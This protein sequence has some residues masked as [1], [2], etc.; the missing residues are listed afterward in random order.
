MLL[1]VQIAEVNNP[2]FFF[3]QRMEILQLP[4]GLG[5]FIHPFTEEI[6]H[7]LETCDG[8]TGFMHEG[9]HVDDP[10]RFTRPWFTWPDALF[11]KFVDKC[12]A[13]GVI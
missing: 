10:T 6:L 3:N 11:C 12:I 8:D 9:F 4:E 2:L 13:E 7:M 5:V 1:R